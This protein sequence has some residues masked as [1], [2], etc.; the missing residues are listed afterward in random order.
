MPWLSML[1]TWLGLPISLSF[2]R[3]TQD[4]TGSEAQSHDHR[5]GLEQEEEGLQA[6]PGILGGLGWSQ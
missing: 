2:F 5:Q 4:C 6:L 3:H 1:G